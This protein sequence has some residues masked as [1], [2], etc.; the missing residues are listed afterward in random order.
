[1]DQEA[2]IAALQEV[3]ARLK[4]AEAG[5]EEWKEKVKTLQEKEDTRM[6]GGDDEA[7]SRIFGNCLCQRLPLSPG[8][9][10]GIQLPC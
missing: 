8:F 6:I 9:L 5:V 3:E 1:M 7:S 4:E 2:R 10:V